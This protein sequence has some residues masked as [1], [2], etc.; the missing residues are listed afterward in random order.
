VKTQS[1]GPGHSPQ[2][3]AQPH[4]PS[5]GALEEKITHLTEEAAKTASRYKVPILVGIVAILAIVAV[6][7][8]VSTLSRQQDGARS[9]KLYQL[10]QME[11]AQ[12]RAE[13]PALQEELE[14]TR[15]EPAFV[16]RYARWLYEQN[17][18]G[19][20][21]QALALIAAARARHPENLIIELTAGEL[22]QV[23]AANAGFV[24]PAL[25]PPPP[26]PAPETPGVA[27]VA[28]V[29]AAPPAPGQPPG[30]GG[31]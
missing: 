11:A 27:P 9:E 2:P 20:R 4:P 18:P 15:I 29:E 13:G 31:R 6:S 16:S 22:E 28:P 23:H 1:Q 21:E 10:F 19:D 30:P 8:L 17:Q 3:H 25:T 24:L 7:G 12:I 14:G 26:P 5:S